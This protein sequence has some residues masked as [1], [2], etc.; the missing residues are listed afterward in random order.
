MRSPSDVAQIVALIALFSLASRL[1]RRAIYGV[2]SDM[3]SLAQT[4]FDQ[5]PQAN[6]KT[7][8]HHWRNALIRSF[9]S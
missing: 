1:Q 6:I 8:S 4:T 3:G 2:Q 5:V 7:S 9:A